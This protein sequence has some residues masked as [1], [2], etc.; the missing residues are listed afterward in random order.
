[1]VQTL[2][3]RCRGLGLPGL[4][5]AIL[6]AAQRNQKKKPYC[7]FIWEFQ[8]NASKFH[9]VRTRCWTWSGA[10]SL[11]GELRCSRKTKTATKTPNTQNCNST[12]VREKHVLVVRG[13]PL[14]L[15]SL[16]GLTRLHLVSRESEKH[17]GVG[18]GEH[19]CFTEWSAGSCPPIWNTGPQNIPPYMVS[20]FRHHP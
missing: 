17:D 7:S 9:V 13:S 20:G 15:E 14:L 2:S 4:G 12:T 1:M 16:M 11:V 19:W 8:I 6:H 10:P 18:V 5:A 3:A